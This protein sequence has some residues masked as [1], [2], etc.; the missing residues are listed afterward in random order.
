MSLFIDL[1]RHDSLSQSI[2]EVRMTN[3]ASTP[4]SPSYTRLLIGM[5]VYVGILL[6]FGLIIC[7][8]LPLLI[9]HIANNQRI[10]RFASQ[11]YTYPLPPQTELIQRRPIAWHHPVNG[12]TCMVSVSAILATSLNQEQIKAYY[13]DV[14]FPRLREVSDVRSSPIYTPTQEQ[15]QYL[16]QLWEEAKWA[17]VEVTFEQPLPDG[18][19]QF[20]ISI[21]EPFFDGGL[22]PR[23]EFP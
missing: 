19:K 12:G 14:K 21:G 8:G 1:A 2:G 11:L 3:Q 17:P 7:C 4:S 18:R 22:D 20:E 23:C 9:Q 6:S 16:D 10:E 13:A 15:Q 5:C